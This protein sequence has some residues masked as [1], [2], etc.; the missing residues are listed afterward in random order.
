MGSVR[1]ALQHALDLEGP[2]NRPRVACGCRAS[3]ASPVRSG[4]ECPNGGRASSHETTARMYAADG[5]LTTW[6]APRGTHGQGGR[7]ALSPGHRAGLRA[8]QP[9]SNLQGPTSCAL[10]DPGGS[11]Y[12]GQAAGRIAAT[13]G[14]ASWLARHWEAGMQTSSIPRRDFIAYSSAAIAGL[15]ALRSSLARAFPARPGEEVV[16]WMD[17]PPP[18]ARRRCR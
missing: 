2:A 13:L 9:A 8:A 5:F 1:N 12:N 15:I 7:T 18:R 14:G 10:P 6:I 17:Q 11:E 3:S 16:P 4:Q